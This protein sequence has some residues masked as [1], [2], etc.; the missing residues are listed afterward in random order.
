MT[1]EGQ[2][3][4]VSRR[5][6]V[7][8]AAWA[9]PAVPIIVAAPAH[10]ASPECIQI[11]LGN[12]ACKWPGAT[13][14]YSYNLELCFKNTCGGTYQVWIQ[15]I[16]NNANKPFA[17]CGASGFEDEAITLGPGF[18]DCIGPYAYSSCSSASTIRIYGWVGV[19]GAAGTEYLIDEVATSG[20][21][22]LAD[23]SNGTPC[24]AL[25]TGC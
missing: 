10:A 20:R 9:V 24:K 17:K 18:N 15:R 1:E 16:E 8:G 3:K 6:L 23:C 21:A 14:Y 13:N 5:T 19:K 22:E 7:K 25:P 12:N 11:T 2:R 4:G